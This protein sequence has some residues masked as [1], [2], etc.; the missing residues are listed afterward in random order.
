MTEYPLTLNTNTAAAAQLKAENKT[1]SLKLPLMIYPPHTAEAKL[2]R[3]LIILKIM[4]EPKK[5]LRI[6]H[7]LFCMFWICSLGFA[8][9]S[10]IP[11]HIQLFYFIKENKDPGNVDIDILWVS[12]QLEYIKYLFPAFLFCLSQCQHANTGLPKILVFHLDRRSVTIIACA[13]NARCF[14]IICI[15]GLT[16]MYIESDN[17]LCKNV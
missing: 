13:L 7:L 1:Q 15:F 14:H 3:I 6:L 10:L 4:T 9:R 16:S 17:L 12:I 2:T 11:N 5:N 8:F